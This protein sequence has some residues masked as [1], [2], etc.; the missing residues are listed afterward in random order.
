GERRWALL[1]T[2]PAGLAD[3]AAAMYV[4]VEP[5]ANDINHTRYF[6]LADEQ[7]AVRGIYESDRDDAVERLV[8]DA[9]ALAGAPPPGHTPPRADAA[10]GGEIYAALG[11]GACH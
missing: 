3:L 10:T 5:S 8:S 9:E 11:C 6:F 7:G 4:A 2:T 1:S